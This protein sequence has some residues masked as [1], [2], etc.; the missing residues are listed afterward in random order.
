[1]DKVKTLVMM[2]TGEGHPLGKIN[3]VG[4]TGA[5]HDFGAASQCQAWS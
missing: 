3:G 1:M 5:C 2:G 4:H